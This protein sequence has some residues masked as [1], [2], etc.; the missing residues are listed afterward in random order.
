MDG[1]VPCLKEKAMPLNKGVAAGLAMLFFLSACLPGIAGPPPK[2]KPPPPPDYF[3]LRP[4]YWWNYNS[5][6]QSGTVSGFTV[7]VKAADRLPDGVVTYLVETVSTGFKP[8]QDVYAKPKG[9]VLMLRQQFLTTGDTGVYAPVK[10][11]LKNP[12]R[13]GDTWEWSGTGTAMNVPISEVN[14]VDGP[15]EVIVPAGK[16][17]AMRVTTQVV[18]SGAPVKKIYWYAPGVGMVKSATDSGS[19]QSE[20]QL[21]KYNLKEEKN[22]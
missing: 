11:Y 2:K 20:T 19:V 18:Q 15:E 6:T 10:Q 16:F 5:I 8:F 3:P 7:T 22:V 13:S 14:A 12:L 9:W 1:W 21:L 17:R 4:G